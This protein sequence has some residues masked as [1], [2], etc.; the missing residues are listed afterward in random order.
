MVC[1]VPTLVQLAMSFDVVMW[2]PIFKAAFDRLKQAGLDQM[3][4]QTLGGVVTDLDRISLNL[5]LVN[6]G[7]SIKGAVASLVQHRLK[8]AVEN[9]QRCSLDV[10]TKLLP[11]FVEN[12]F[13]SMEIVKELKIT[14]IAPEAGLDKVLR[15]FDNGLVP[16][17][18][19]MAFVLKQ[20]LGCM[21]RF[22]HWRNCASYQRKLISSSKRDSPYFN[23]FR[24]RKNSQ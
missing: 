12:D 3:V 11:L 21:K 24:V 8:I 15:C 18:P 6:G 14:L 19:S 16:A 2:D 7:D 20:W 13:V 17:L 22:A 1:N 10:E 4:W 23:V 9:I 5:S